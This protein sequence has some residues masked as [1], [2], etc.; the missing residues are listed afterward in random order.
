MIQHSIPLS[1]VR[2]EMEVKFPEV[3]AAKKRRRM[4]YFWGLFWVYFRD[5]VF[6]SEGNIE[7]ETW[8]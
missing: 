5:V 8:S 4:R 7:D 6:A 1:H 3:V 2:S